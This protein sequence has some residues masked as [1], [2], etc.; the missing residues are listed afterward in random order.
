MLSLLLLCRSLKGEQVKN[1][2]AEQEIVL[3][4]LPHFCLIIMG[5]IRTPNLTIFK[6]TLKLTSGLNAQTD[7]V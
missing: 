2:K 5:L 7:G 3:K 1:G 6:P 4:M